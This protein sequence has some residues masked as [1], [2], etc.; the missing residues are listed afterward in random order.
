[1]NKDKVSD[2]LD[3][4]KEIKQKNEL[5][6]LSKTKNNFDNSRLSR[7]CYKDPFVKK[8]LIIEEASKELR[9]SVREEDWIKMK[10]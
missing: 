7:Y 9:E 1:M 5:D 2:L 8:N 4:I 10:N 6:K 3:K